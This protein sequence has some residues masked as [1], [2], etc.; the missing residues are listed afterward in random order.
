MV[1]AATLAMA[2][3]ILLLLLVAHRRR[4]AVEA[5]RA[6]LEARLGTLRGTA[7]RIAGGDLMTA[8][9]ARGDGYDDFERALE[10]IRSELVGKIDELDRRNTEVR[11]LNKELR[12]QIAERSKHLTRALADL[13]AMRPTIEPGTLFAERYEI[14]AKLGAGTHGEVF[15]AKRTTD[16]LA[17]AVKILKRVDDPLVIARFMREARTLAKLDHPNVVA[18]HDIGIAPTGEVFLV[19][20][21]IRGPSLYDLRM[22]YGDQKWALPLLRDVAAALVAVHAVDVVHRDLKPANVVLDDEPEH[23]VAKLIDFGIARAEHEQSPVNADTKEAENIEL[24]EHGSATAETATIRTRDGAVVGTPAYLAPE[25]VLSPNPAT[26][27]ADMFS[28]GVMAYE[29]LSGKRPFA[30][31]PYN[32]VRSRRSLPVPPS[33]TEHS[34]DLEPAIAEMIHECLDVSIGKRPDA[35]HAERVLQAALARRPDDA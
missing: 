10:D 19:T 31:P 12:Y 29:L 9:P 17:V 27:A 15:R 21:L 35:T 4:L 34:A 7:E 25:L 22:R 18:I 26:P 30:T 23:A 14:V 28:F 20:Q 5:T 3:T 13:R 8:V 16:E 33:L 11:G 24:R 1:V 2:I 6:E 32:L